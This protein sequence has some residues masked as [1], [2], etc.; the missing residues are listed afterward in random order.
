MFTRPPI[1]TAGKD[2]LMAHLMDVVAADGDYFAPVM[3]PANSV[4]ILLNEC[5]DLGSAARVYRERLDE[6]AQLART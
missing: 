2:A 6:I 4:R 1:D 3:L 5:R